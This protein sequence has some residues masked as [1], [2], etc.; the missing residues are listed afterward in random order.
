[1]GVKENG[2]VKYFNAE[3]GFGFIAPASGR[4]DIFVHFSAIVGD[5]YKT[6]RAGEQ[7]EFEIVDSPRG[8]RAENVRAAGESLRAP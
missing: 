4:P 5:V 7:V 1:M 3:R 8:F 6:L 2:T